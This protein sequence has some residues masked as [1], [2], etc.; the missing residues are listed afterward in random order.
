MYIFWI[1]IKLTII[2]IYCLLYFYFE[3]CQ[4]I[5][6]LNLS[7]IKGNTLEIE[8]T[9]LIQSVDILEKGKTKTHTNLHLNVFLSNPI[10][11]LSMYS[12]IAYNTHPY[13]AILV[14]WLSHT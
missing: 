3:N 12:S 10:Y 14:T 2:D 6:G 1:F 4:V 5:L 7:R 11:S 9:I 8:Y 13:L